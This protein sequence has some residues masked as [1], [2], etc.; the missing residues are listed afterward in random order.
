MCILNINKIYK[1]QI[2]VIEILGL[3][4]YKIFIFIKGKNI[5]LKLIEVL[6]GCIKVDISYDI[7]DIGRLIRYF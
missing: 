7:M 2:L 6:Y 5:I 1:C 3:F 4:F